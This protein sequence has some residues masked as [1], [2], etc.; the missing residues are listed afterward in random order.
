MNVE[1]VVSVE[2]IVKALTSG[3]FAEKL[4]AQRLLDNE[5]ISFDRT[6]AKNE[7]L[8]LIKD[9]YS[10]RRQ[11]TDETGESEDVRCWLLSSLGRLPNGE[12]TGKILRYHINLDYEPNEWARYWALEAVVRS[13]PSD[14]L[15]ICT[16]IAQADPDILPKMLAAAVLA[17]S[18]DEKY[19]KL[20]LDS[21]KDSSDEREAQMKKWGTLRAL[22]F[23]YL[24]FTV[25][26]IC[27]LTDTKLGDI[28]YEAIVALG[29]VEPQSRYAEKAGLA[30]VA[31]ITNNR[32]Y[33]YWDS[34]RVRAIDS[35]R[36]LKIESTAS[37]LL[38]ELTDLNPAIA[39]A[40]ALA[41]EVILGPATVVSRIL[42]L[43]AKPEKQELSRFV[44]GLR[45]MRD[46]EAIARELGAASLS[47]SGVTQEYARRLL[48][49]VGGASAFERLR[50]L[51]KSTEHYLTVLDQAD[52]RLRSLF[53]DTV[54]E[55][56]T[57]FKIVIAMDVIVFLVGVVLIAFS[58]YLALHESPPFTS[59]TSW[60]TGSAGVLATIYGRFFAQPRTQVET[61]TQ[62]LSSLKAVFLGYLRQLRQADQAFTLRVFEEKPLT[63]EE[64]KSFNGVIEETME[65]AMQHLSTKT[66]ASIDK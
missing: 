34:S 20:I 30:L 55:A 53:E 58:I 32:K 47:Q 26:A 23:V 63:P 48:S 9:D 14:I 29:N 51:T 56:R 60:L 35:L 52:E 45:E 21:L 6:A 17:R 22:R 10:P 11:L 61:S 66:V 15:D 4:E 5:H 43:L 38:E 37:L 25:Y 2:W 16:P 27:P 3:T 41:L 57:G 19:Q 28:A 7:L 62:Y 46:Q 8:R 50:S 44:R 65:K 18:G 31:F 40:S 39:Q 49:E 1:R 64:T 13:N 59:W 33:Q 36:Q 24:P 42:E 12:E 54:K